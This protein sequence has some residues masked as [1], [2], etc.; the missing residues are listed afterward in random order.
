MQDNEVL[1]SVPSHIKIGDV[2]H[3]QLMYIYSKL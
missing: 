2:V 1:I 3:Y